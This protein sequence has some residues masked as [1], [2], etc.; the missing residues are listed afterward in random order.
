M[1]GPVLL[2]LLLLYVETIIPFWVCGC[3]HINGIIIYHTISPITARALLVLA[4]PVVRDRAGSG[5]WPNQRR[6][7]R[8]RH[9][10]PSS[11]AGPQRGES[12][13]APVKTFHVAAVFALVAIEPSPPTPSCS[14]KTQSGEKFEGAVRCRPLGTERW[15][16]ANKRRTSR[17]RRSRRRP[18]G[19]S[20]V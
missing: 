15:T 7:T 1:D 19:N 20:E 16:A 12:D 4:I 9:V 3:L 10:I 2:L 5:G 14:G 13:S 8:Q 17:P 18:P 6:D 11:S